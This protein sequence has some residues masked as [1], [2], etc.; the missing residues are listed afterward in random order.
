[1]TYEKILEL[2]AAL[3]NDVA[4]DAYTNTV[5]L[6]YLNIARMDLEEIFE[7]NSIPVTS[8]TSA[9][10]EL[11]IGTTAV[12]FGTN[13]PLPANLIE[14]QELYE[15]QS[16]LNN[17]FRVD[18]KDYITDYILGNTELSWF[19][20]WSWQDQEIRLPSLIVAQDIK[21]DYIKSLFTP[22]V[23]SEIGLENSIKNT[24][25]FFQYRVAALC[26]EFIDENTERADSLN[27]NA[28]S[29]LERSLG[30]SV[31]GMQTISYRRRPF[32]AGYKARR[33]VV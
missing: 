33:I 32:R 19:R 28:N 23:L 15:S 22:L 26:S 4:R 17:F 16:G 9:V 30:I 31:K 25:S 5:M 3:L 11:P 21:I 27:N 12:G 14:I 18:K 2:S 24:A 29:A 6:P 7:L 1:M 13:P 20:V 8:E 10:I